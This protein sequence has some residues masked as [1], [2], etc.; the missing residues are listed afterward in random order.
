MLTAGLSLR[1][2]GGP[3]SAG[4]ARLSQHPAGPLLGLLTQITRD[5]PGW[6]PYHRHEQAQAPRGTERPVC[7]VSPPRLR[8][9]ATDKKVEPHRDFPIRLEV[10]VL[11]THRVVAM[12]SLSLF[13]FGEASE[14]PDKALCFSSRDLVQPFPE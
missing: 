14:L 5:L 13:G 9:R 12:L 4:S 1:L 6:A 8:F 10:A 2:H 7:L 3:S 11:G